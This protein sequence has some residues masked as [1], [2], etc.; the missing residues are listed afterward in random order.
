MDNSTFLP[1]TPSVETTTP[2]FSRTSRSFRPLHRTTT[3]MLVSSSP[4]K[5]RSLRLPL[6]LVRGREGERDVLVAREVTLSAGDMVPDCV[7]ALN[8]GALE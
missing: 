7:R 4:S 5:S 8:V 2:L 1:W 6:P 3:W